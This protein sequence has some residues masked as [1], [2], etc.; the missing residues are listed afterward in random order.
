VYRGEE[1]ET[2]IWITEVTKPIMCLPYRSFI[3]KGDVSCYAHLYFNIKGDAPCY[4]HLSFIL[5]RDA[6]SK[7][8]LSL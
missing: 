8:C 5:N 3:I 1:N 4:V 2:D 7:T 6:R